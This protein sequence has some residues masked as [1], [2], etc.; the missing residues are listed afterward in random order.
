MKKEGVCRLCGRSLV[1]VTG[2]CAREYTY[3]L[4][5]MSDEEIKKHLGL[6]YIS[7]DTPENALPDHTHE[8]GTVRKEA[9]WVFTTSDG[10][11]WGTEV[12]S[13]RA[14]LDLAL[15]EIRRLKNRVNFVRT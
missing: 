10:R 5:G 15:T 8:V 2:L 14:E 4:K 13:L 11:E 1:L 6:G 9:V 3:K 12:E 7:P